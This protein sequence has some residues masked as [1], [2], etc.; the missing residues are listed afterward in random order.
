MTIPKEIK[1]LALHLTK[2]VK[3]MHIENYK[4]LTKEIRENLSKWKY[5]VHELEGAT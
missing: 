4:M 5:C 2:S 3:D 1:Y